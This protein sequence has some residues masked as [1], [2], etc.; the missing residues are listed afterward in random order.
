MPIATTDRDVRGRDDTGLNLC[1]VNGFVDIAAGNA[2][3][4]F[5]TFRNTS[6][7][8]NVLVAVIGLRPHFI[9]T[10]AATL[11]F[12]QVYRFTTTATPTGGTTLVA[13]Q[14]DNGS[15]PPPSYDARISS[16]TALT[17][18]G[19]TFEAN[20]MFTT[21]QPRQDGPHNGSDNLLVA[22]VLLLRPGDGF[23]VRLGATA[24]GHDAFTINV[25]FTDDTPR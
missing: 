9:G 1:R 21:P 2:G 12:Y 3:D 14:L 25:A 22:G 7:T 17:V 19:V 4:A 18:T 16:G 10:N 11:Q 6:T 15:V 24:A 8:H 5:F 23:A 20:A 13:A